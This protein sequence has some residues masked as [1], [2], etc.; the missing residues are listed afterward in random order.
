M[1]KW[2]LW[3]IRGLKLLSFSL[4]L[5]SGH[6]YEQFFIKTVR[7]P[8]FFAFKPLM[9]TSL[10]AIFTYQPNLE[11]NKEPDQV[12]SSGSGADRLT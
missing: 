1:R 6:F 10:I 9:A 12:N 4:K 3:I 2:L 7:G 5:F 8:L 11:I